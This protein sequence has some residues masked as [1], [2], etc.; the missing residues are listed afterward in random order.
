LRLNGACSL[1]LVK[2]SSGSLPERALC[3][4]EA[5]QHSDAQRVVVYRGDQRY[6]RARQDDDHQPGVTAQTGSLDRAALL[7]AVPFERRA[8]EAALGV[9][10]SLVAILRGASLSQIIDGALADL[11]QQKPPAPAKRLCPITLQL[12]QSSDSQREKSTASYNPSWSKICS[13][14]HDGLGVVPA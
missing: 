3:L 8:L 7:A 11:E 12:R 14:C 4:C 10:L 5:L 13:R 1:R 9:S 6:V 2:S